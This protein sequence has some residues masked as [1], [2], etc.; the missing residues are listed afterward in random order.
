MTN[1]RWKI[2]LCWVVSLGTLLPAG[3][4]PAATPA[5]T[6]GSAVLA[7][8][9]VLEQ[10]TLRGQTAGE[11]LTSVR[12]IGQGH[13]L[14]TVQTDEAGRFQFANVTPG[15]YRVETP[16]S[17]TLV[18]CWA[19]EVAPPSAKSSLTLDSM[20]IRGQLDHDFGAIGMLT[21]AVGIAGLTTGIIGLVEAKNAQD[22]VDELRG[23]ISP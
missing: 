14:A 20:V 8:D 18:R 11:A 17:V 13:T 4:V 3:S 12:L 1:G 6:Q 21:A 16:Q 22:E 2:V 5:K 15:Q 9:V 10:G 19:S 23:L 7:R